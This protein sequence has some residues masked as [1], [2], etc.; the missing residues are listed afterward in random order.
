MCILLS[1]HHDKS[2]PHHHHPRDP[3][4]PFALPHLPFK[5]PSF[6]NLESL[7]PSYFSYIWK[8]GQEDFVSYIFPRSEVQC[9]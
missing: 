4:Y 1:A 8:E 2:S 7:H 9:L 3:L 5:R 6:L